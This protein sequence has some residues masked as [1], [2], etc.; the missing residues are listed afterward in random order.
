MRASERAYEALREE[1]LAGILAPG[2]VLAEVEQ[3]ERLGVSRTPLREALARLAAD[4]LVQPSGRGLVVAPLSPDSVVAL[5][6][7]R[8]PLEAAAAG[9]AARRA[10]ARVFAELARRFRDEAPGLVDA[11]GLDA[12]YALTA[13]LDRAID[14]ACANAYFA[15]ALRNVRLHSARARR[16]AAADPGRLREAAHEHLVIARAI[17]EGDAALAEHATHVHL[18]Q[19]LRHVLAAA[20]GPVAAPASAPPAP[21]PPA[22]DPPRARRSA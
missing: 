5:Y 8:E 22:S 17:A 11:G 10:D 18:R 14:D 13:E 4:G 2:T 7:L 6:E 19:S 12:Y 9:L 1:L 15:Q 21:R 16:L 20:P 3:S